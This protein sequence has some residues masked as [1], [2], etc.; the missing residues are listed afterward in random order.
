MGPDELMWSIE[1]RREKSNFAAILCKSVLV[2]E[3]K[4]FWN[5][6]KLISLIKVALI[7]HAEHALN[8]RPASMPPIG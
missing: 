4:S 3:L 2:N 5:F 6:K 1:N 7:N 8:G